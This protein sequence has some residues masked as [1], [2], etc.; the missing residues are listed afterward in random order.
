HRLEAVGLTLAYVLGLASVFTALGVF[1]AKG[2]QA[3]GAQLGSPP[4]ALGLAAF[5]VVLASSMFGAFEI[6]LPPGLATR[7]SQVGGSSAI[8]AFLMGGV[9]G[10]L[11]APCTG[12]VLTGLLTFVATSQNVLLGASLLFVYALGM[13]L[14]FVLIGVFAVHLPKAGP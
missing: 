12:A 3:F 2:G 9:S 8:G 6:S 13:G 14:P 5:M 1:A 7:L 4:V 10:F 11:A